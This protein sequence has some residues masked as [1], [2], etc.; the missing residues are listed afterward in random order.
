MIC[1]T[2]STRPSAR[3]RLLA[4]A[5]ALFYEH[6]VHVVGIDWILSDSGVSKAALYSNFGSKDELVRSYLVGRHERRMAR[7]GRHLD[8]A[9]DDRSRLLALFSSQAE[10]FAENGPRGCAFLRAA[11]EAAPDE[12]AIEVTAQYRVE[13]LEKLTGIAR[14]AGVADPPALAEQLILLYDGAAAS[15]QFDGTGAAIAQARTM[16]EAIVDAALA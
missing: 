1:V 9:W 10:A 11:A 13:Q 4:S 15:T 16:A 14:D 5:D 6:G 3:E 12:A 8:A 2:T 7:W